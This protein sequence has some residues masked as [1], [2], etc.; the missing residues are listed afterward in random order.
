MRSWVS[1][2][3]SGIRKLAAELKRR[4]EKESGRTRIYDRFCCWNGDKVCDTDR[5]SSAY[6]LAD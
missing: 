4:K 5:G 1:A 2:V 6:S 3:A